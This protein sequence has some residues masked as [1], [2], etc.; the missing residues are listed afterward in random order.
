MHS[1]NQMMKR[2][3]A[4]VLVVA[5]LVSM[6]DFGFA[7]RAN[8]VSSAE[9]VSYGS[10]IANTVEG[11]GTAE[12]NILKSG[13][14]AGGSVTYQ[15]PANSDELIRVDAENKKITVSSYRDAHG[16]QWTV[17]ECRVVFDGGKETV[18][19]TNGEGTFTYEGDAYSVEADYELTKAADVKLTTKLLNAPYWLAKGVDNLKVLSSLDV[20]DTLKVLA[21]NKDMLDILAYGY[22]IPGT[23]WTVTFDGCKDNAKNMIDQM[24][25]NGGKLD[26]QVMAENY[27]ASPSKIAYLIANGGS[28]KDAASQTYTDIA[29]IL[30]ALNTNKSNIVAT[31]VVD[32]GQLTVIINSLD[33]WLSTVKPVVD[34]AWTILENADVLKTGLTSAQY[35]QLDNLVM[36]DASLASRPFTGTVPTTLKVAKATVSAETN[37]FTVTV[38]VEAQVVDRNSVNTAAT[39]AMPTETISFKMNAGST[40]DQI[41]AQITASGIEEQALDAWDAFYAINTT[42]YLRDVSI[43]LNDV[44]TLGEDITYTISYAPKMLDVTY[45]DGYAE[46]E[47]TPVSVPYGYQMLLPRYAGDRVYDY[48]VNGMDADQ[49]SV[50]RITESTAISRVQGKAWENHS[51]GKLISNNFASADAAAQSI[52]ASPALMTGSFRLRTPTAADSLLTMNAA[53][54][55]YNVTAKAY[56]ANTGDL[57]WVPASATLHGGEADGTVVNFTTLDDRI[58]MATID[59]SRSFDQVVVNYRVALPW[60]VLGISEAEAGAILNLPHTLAT[61]AS[62]QLAVMNKLNEQ[63]GNMQTLNDNLNAIKV[64][65]NGSDLPQAAKDAVADLVAN[66]SNGTSLYVY[67]LLTAYRACGSDAEKLA[68]YFRNYDGV[69]GLKSQIDRVC[70]DFKVLAVDYRTDFEAFLTSMNFGDYAEK[71]DKIYESLAEVQSGMKTPNAAINLTSAGLN[72]LAAQIVN[73]IDNTQAYTGSLELPVLETQLSV[74]APDKISVSITVQVQNSDGDVIKEASGS[75][76]FPAEGGT[77][78]LTA[79]QAQQL[80]ALK[81]SLYESLLTTQADKKHYNTVVTD[82][83]LGEGDVLTGSVQAATV[84]GP[85]TYTVHFEDETGADLG[86]VA[87]PFDKPTIELPACGDGVNRYDYWINGQWKSDA[88]YTFTV[89]QIDQF[90]GGSYIITR[91]TVNVSREKIDQ[92]V[93]QLNQAIVDANMTY[94]MNGRECLKASVI[95]VE[96]NGQ[97]SLVLRIS[98][99]NT[100]NVQNALAKV[101][102]VLVNTSYDYV[103][104][105]DSPLKANDQIHLQCLI[106]TM[107]NSG[108]GLDTITGMIDANGNLNEMTL[109]GSPVGMVEDDIPVGGAYIYDA[110]LYGAKMM[111]TTLFL[112][113]SAE[114]GTELP[115]YLTME[116]FDRSANALR[117]ARNAALDIQRFVDITAADG[118]LNMTLKLTDGQYAAVVSAMLATGLVSKDDLTNVDPV[119]LVHYLYD[120]L[121]P[122]VLDTNVTG[123]TLN[124]TLKELGFSVNLSAYNSIAP[125]LRHLIE[126][127]EVSEEIGQTDTY[128]AK[129]SYSL[130]ELIDSMNLGALAGLIAESESG[131]HMGISLKVENLGKSYVAM[132][133]D[134]GASGLNKLRYYSS[135][136]ALQ[137][138]ISNLKSSSLVIL[139]SDCEGDLVINSRG[140]LLDLNGKTVYGN[141]TANATTVILD[142]SKMNDGTVTG[143]VSGNLSI[144]AGHYSMDVSAFIPA[145]GYVLVDGEVRN[146]L[147]QW[148]E[149]EAGNYT[150]VLNGDL[151]KLD[152][153]PS[154]ASLALELAY[155][156]VL[157]HFACASLALDDY[158]IYSV[159]VND[160]IGIVGGGV[161]AEL[162]NNLLSCIKSE[163]ITGFTNDLLNV[164]TDFNAMSDAM[165]YHDGVL[166]TYTM[167]TGDWTIE[168][169][170]IADGNY[171]TANIVPNSDVVTRKVTLQIRDNESGDFAALV[172]QLKDIAHIDASVNL[173]D[174]TYEGGSVNISGA[175][176]VNA[177]FNLNTN[178]D[179]AAVLAILLADQTS[180]AV[181]ENLLIAVRSYAS[182]GRTGMLKD[183]IEAVTIAQLVSAL[184]NMQRDTFAEVMERFDLSALNNVRELEAAYDDLLVMMGRIASVLQISG[185]NRT[186]G[187]YADAYG[188]YDLSKA[189]RFNTD[190][191]VDLTA[192]L[193]VRILINLLDEDVPHAIVV[194]DDNGVVIYSGDNL[195]EAFAH[196]QGGYTIQINGY[197]ILDGDVTIATNIEIVGADYIDLNGNAILLT[198]GGS[199]KTDAE[200]NVTTNV[201]YFEVV[202]VN[203]TYVLSALTPSFTGSVIVNAP[204]NVIDGYKIDAEKGYIFLDVDPFNGITPAQLKEYLT[205]M[206]INAEEVIYNVDATVEGRV[207]NGATLTVV[208]K[209]HD[210][211]ATK[212]YTIIIMGDTNCNGVTDSGDAVLMMQHYLY[213]AVL[214]EPVKLAADMNQNG[215]ID[216][217]DAVKNATKYTLWEENTYESELN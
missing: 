188:T 187:S 11:L 61:D 125:I 35:I 75:V 204:E 56:R 50:I 33:S 159:N 41:L 37:R 182:T 1:F 66:C 161:N 10:M 146:D 24:N 160:L 171:L 72:E 49:G 25:A 184:K 138:A 95:P 12:K 8:A 93:A 126:N 198:H 192:N 149:D 70:A 100:E 46:D 59:G 139:L 94:I 186:I 157:K 27:K 17:T 28:V 202:R 143:D 65:V 68:F 30:N 119:A 133:I 112:G 51:L 108:M 130:S 141:L 180:G 162:A 165:K 85:T 40:G 158:Q 195:N 166:K 54:G 203:G 60:E 169:D 78:T 22:V 167:T 106:D 129:F 42:N 128:K 183:A 92:L 77:I 196:A 201:P 45:G 21:D 206:A 26:L 76:A 96:Y 23:T 140:V 101:A 64:A 210:K 55:V 174:I 89:A 199:L 69:T 116:D 200:L 214:A 52:L 109:P 39:V 110:A 179:Y 168:L 147:F 104:I 117:T 152:Q 190:G 18:A 193:D 124:N 213:G 32:E 115:L 84:Y 62:A 99:E 176:N 144:T 153:T 63:Y 181:R 145:S 13:L 151:L 6:A 172:E 191:K 43:D 209:N 208:A 80:N 97:L 155:D 44:Y 31:G 163:G 154:I 142:S 120:I 83:I 34:D 15:K 53:S 111:E 123:T 114:A 16:N 113:A 91:R 217:G 29:N 150:I 19:L 73:S 131:L 47:K 205:V 185:G 215:E 14:L 58:Y 67:D 7:L 98:P 122:A 82:T 57:W 211:Q 103:G 178:P 173:D 170:R 194:V 127:V 87:F 216:A 189:F 156:V 4:M 132:V 74:D 121:E 197:V 88:S 177:V 79:A 71:I 3:L 175:G 136:A 148:T 135:A 137:Q 86:S 20:Q 36:A 9:T 134:P 164:L 105:G 81:N 102:E 48:T 107:L 118:R 212:Q 5:M 2:G 90:A 38:K 207:V